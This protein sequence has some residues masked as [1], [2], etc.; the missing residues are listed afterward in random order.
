METE[1]TGE[2]PYPLARIEFRTVGRQEVKSETFGPVLPPIPVQSSMM[3]L[4]VVRDHHDASS[5]VRADGVKLLQEF[6][7][8]DGVEFA[9]LPAEEELAVAQA[10]RPKSNPRSSGSDEG[11]ERDL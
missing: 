6:P 8:G 10:D 7:A 9:S 3:V 2:F 11:A 4:G 5:R 1:P